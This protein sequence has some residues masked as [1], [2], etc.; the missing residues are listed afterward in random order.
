MKLSR[1]PKIV[2]GY[3]LFFVYIIAALIG[4]IIFRRISPE[5]EQM[6]NV[7]LQ[8]DLLFGVGLSAFCLIVIIGL[9]LCKEWGRLFAISLNSILLFS[10][11]I[12]S[13]GVYFYTIIAYGEGTFSLGT[14]GIVTSILSLFFLIGITRP[15][16]KMAY[17]VTQQKD[18]G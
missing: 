18:K 5:W 6:E 2:W 9:V 16:I 12:M 10:T 3:I 4:G 15:K 7:R 13:T 17:L 14:D 11:F 1:I 8:Y